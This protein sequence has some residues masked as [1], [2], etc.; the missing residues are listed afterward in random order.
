MLYL[1]VFNQWLKSDITA[2]LDTRVLYLS[3]FNQWL[4]SDI[5]ATLDTRVLYLSVFFQIE[6]SIG[7]AQILSACI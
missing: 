2:I 4:K 5:T 7:H 6:Q 3:V 1:S